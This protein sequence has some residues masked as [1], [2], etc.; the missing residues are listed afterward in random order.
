MAEFLK[1]NTASKMITPKIIMLISSGILHKMITPKI[2]MMSSSTSRSSRIKML[3]SSR[4]MIFP[5]KTTKEMQKKKIKPLQH[6][7]S[8]K[9]H[10]ESLTMHQKLRKKEQKRSL[11]P[12]V[13]KKKKETSLTMQP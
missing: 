1:V 2:T 7:L 8:Q 12:L 9:N 6:N 10:K 3:R 11:R 5:M 13:R 4:K